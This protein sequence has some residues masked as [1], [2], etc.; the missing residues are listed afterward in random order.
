M[1]TSILDE[2][3]L[4]MRYAMLELKP[5]SICQN[6]EFYFSKAMNQADWSIVYNLFRELLLRNQNNES[7]V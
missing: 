6:L 3:Y 5:Q 4:V 7:L 1:D 2:G